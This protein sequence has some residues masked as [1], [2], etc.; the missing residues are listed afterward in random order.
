[1]KQTGQGRLFIYA[2]RNDKIVE[3]RLGTLGKARWRLSL[4]TLQAQYGICVGDTLFRGEIVPAY[5]RLTLIFSSITDRVYRY[6]LGPFSLTGRKN[7]PRL[8]N[9]DL[10]SCARRVRSQSRQGNAV[11]MVAKVADRSVEAVESRILPLDERRACL[12]STGQGEG[13]AQGLLRELHLESGSASLETGDVCF[14]QKNEGLGWG[15]LD[16]K[17]AWR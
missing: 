7:L 13:R 17:R 3:P 8:A 11:R 4:L 6:P 5:V 16:R 1:M 9:R 12:R 2:Y 14:C 15:R 10:V